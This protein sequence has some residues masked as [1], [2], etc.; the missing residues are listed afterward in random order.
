MAR[1]LW[2]FILATLTFTSGAWPILQAEELLNGRRSLVLEGQA[3]RLI[4]DLAG[5]SIADFR[6]R[7]Q[8]VPALGRAQNGDPRRVPGIS[9]PGPLGPAFR[10]GRCNGMPCHGGLSSGMAGSVTD[11]LTITSLGLA[12]HAAMAGGRQTRCPLVPRKALRHCAR[13]DRK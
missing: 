1:P 12:A 5:G 13:G 8:A 6:L 3:A 7:E 4:L 11:W 9:L 2:Q 10:S